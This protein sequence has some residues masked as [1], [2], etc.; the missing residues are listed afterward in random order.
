MSRTGG[1]KTK[2]FILATAERLFAEHGF[3]ETSVDQIAKAAG[4]NK[5]LI[6]YYFKNKEA[7]ALSLFRSVRQDLFA[8]LPVGADSAAPA[9]GR[10]QDEMDIVAKKKDTI[11]LLLME[12]LRSG[13]A[14]DFLFECGEAIAAP[15]LKGKSG[16]A[17]NKVLAREFYTGLIPYTMFLLLKDKWCKYFK[18]TPEQAAEDFVEVFMSSHLGMTGEKKK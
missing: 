6:Y 10:I 5:A 15:L 16:R 4:V 2:A 14:S 18:C 11:A 9:S 13:P 7:L 17:R 8:Q 12:S 3:S 1:E